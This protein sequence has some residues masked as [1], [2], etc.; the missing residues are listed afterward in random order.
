MKIA[1]SEA[2]REELQQRWRRG[3]DV[4]QQARLQAAWLATTGQYT[5]EQI[6][7]AVGRARS[8]IQLWINQFTAGGVAGLLARKKAPG[9][10]SPLQAPAIQAA[11]AEGLRTGRWLTAAQLAAWLHTHHGLRRSAQSLYYWLGKCGGA[12]KVPRPVHI[13][14]DAAAA[15]AFQA[16]LYDKL[17]ALALPAGR[18][19]RIWMADESRYGLHSFTRRCWGRRG[20]R[21]VKPTQQIY[22]WG[23]VYG[24][25]EVVTGQAEFRLMPSVN[26]N[27]LR[28]FLV[29]VAASDAQA[30][31][32]VIWDQAGFHP[33]PGDPGLPAHVHL[34]PLPPYSP[35]LNPVEKLWDLIKDGIA[36]RVFSVLGRLETALA[37][38]LRPFWTTPARTRQLVG[39]GWLYV[40]ANAS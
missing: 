12:L 32:V 15:A 34:L 28:D 38:A 18:P 31:H 22:Q 8:T 17:C 6:A 13:K 27:F 1:V 7:Q 5:Y 2:V 9:R 30:E 11:L 25:L 36:N 37:A 4:R 16:H 26:L 29:Q 35:E 33:R 19:V 40:Q 39:D 20:I 3:D 14:K 24:A 21:V 23:Y 10:A